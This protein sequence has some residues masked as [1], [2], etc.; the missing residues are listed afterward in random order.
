MRLTSIVLV[1][2]VTGEVAT[3]PGKENPAVKFQLVT[4]IT[5]HPEYP[6]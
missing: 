2:V 5:D 6:A 3:N 4:M 1:L